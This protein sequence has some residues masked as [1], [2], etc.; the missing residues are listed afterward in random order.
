MFQRQN[1]IV[2]ININNVEFEKKVK[3]LLF[4]L[5]LRY[6]IFLVFLKENENKKNCRKF[7]LRNVN[8]KLFKKVGVKLQIM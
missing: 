5:L 8:G 7:D 3:Y 4:V 2:I 1:S 6:E